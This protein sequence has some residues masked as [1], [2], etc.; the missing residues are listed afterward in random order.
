MPDLALREIFGNYLVEHAE[1]Y[2]NLVVLDA[3]LSSSTRT[4]KFANKYPDRFFNMGIAEQC[5]MGTAIGLAISGKMPVVSGFTIFTTGRAWEFIRMVCHDQLNVKI[6]TT[7]GGIVGEDGSTHNALEDFSLMASLPNLTILVPCDDIELI[8]MLNFCF[9]YKGPIY[10]RLPRGAF[11]RIHKPGYQFSV[12]NIDV[13]KD[14]SDFCLIGTGYGTV[15]SCEN[16]IDIEKELDISLKIINLPCIKPINE[17]KL[18]SLVSN[19]KGIVVVEEHNVYSGIGNIL[20]RIIS[21]KMPKAM[22]FIG[23]EDTFVRSGN[24]STIL[25][26]YGLNKENIVE[27]LKE[28]IQLE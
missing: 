22:R 21:K 16:A 27:K 26:S 28:L 13:I 1:K 6:I 7:H 25:D 17:Q 15:L 20:A 24:R 5:M 11:S 3:D 2:L 23:I 18:L 9:E 14:G 8:S 10:V 12:D 4:F 19:T